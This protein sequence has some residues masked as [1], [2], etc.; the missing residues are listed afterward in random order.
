MAQTLA[1]APMLIVNI[2]TAGSVDASQL[3]VD[4][5]KTAG[6]PVGFFNRAL[7]GD[8]EDTA[9]FASCDKLAFSLS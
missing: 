1:K 6:I 9:V 8:S 7:G 3:I 4:K 5:A 2:V